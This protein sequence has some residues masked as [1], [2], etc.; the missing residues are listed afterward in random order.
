MIESREFRCIAAPGLLLALIVATAGCESS[1]PAT[2]TR[3]QAASGEAP[4]TVSIAFQARVGERPYGCDSA[5]ATAPFG[6]TVIEPGGLRMFVHDVDLT[7]A[8]GTTERAT[9]VDDDRWQDGAVALLDFE[10]GKGRCRGGTPETNTSV[11]IEAPSQPVT[12][13]VF[14]IGVPFEANHAD[15]AKAAAPLSLTSMHWSWK[16]GYKFMRFDASTGD[17][18]DYTFHLG[19]TQCEGSITNVTG[20]ARPNRPRVS[21]SELDPATAKVAIDVAA[22][23]AASDAE[24]AEARLACLGEKDQASCAPVFRQLGLDLNSGEPVA[25]ASAAQKVFSAR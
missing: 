16:A 5:A 4:D 14:S 6:A 15:P 12:G 20:C 25:D 10:N 24:A 11:V 18:R 2:T 13:I 9:L 23:V 19:S 3:T 1:P 21:L 7:L 8:D 17:D 22:L